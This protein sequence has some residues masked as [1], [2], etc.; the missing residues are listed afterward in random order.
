[1]ADQENKDFSDDIADQSFDQ[2]GDAENGD[3]DTTENGQE[4]QE[5]RYWS[6]YCVLSFNV[7]ASDVLQNHIESRRAP[8]R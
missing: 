7:V 1:M 5:D 3:G 6:F 2:N 4:S 8:R